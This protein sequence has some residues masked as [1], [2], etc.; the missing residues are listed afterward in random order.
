MTGPRRSEGKGVRMPRMLPCAVEMTGTVCCA[1]EEA[2][3]RKKER[4]RERRRDRNPGREEKDWRGDE[5]GGVLLVHNLDMM[6]SSGI[7]GR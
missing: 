7:A 3:E 2:G 6:V 5:G 4:Q 1:D